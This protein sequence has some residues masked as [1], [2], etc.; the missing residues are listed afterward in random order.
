MSGT[1]YIMYKYGGCIFKKRIILVITKV[2]RGYDSL[3]DK[4]SNKL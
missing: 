4:T 2:K 3:K 1:L